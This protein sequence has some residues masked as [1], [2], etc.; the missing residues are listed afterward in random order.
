[1][2]PW[3]AFKVQAFKGGRRPSEGKRFLKGAA[4]KL[5][6]HPSRIICRS[7]ELWTEKGED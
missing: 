3:N 5:L 6:L 4:I 1:M 2:I 7:A